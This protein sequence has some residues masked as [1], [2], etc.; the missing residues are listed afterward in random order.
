MWAYNNGI[1]KGYSSGYGGKFGVND[2]ITREQLAQVLYKYAEYKGY[3]LEYQENIRL[4]FSDQNKISNWAIPAM[5][6]AISKGIINGKGTEDPKLDP[7][8]NATRAEAA[9]MIKSFLEK[10]ADK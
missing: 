8:G 5:E 7:L 10:V 6:W 2:P 1:V 4:S 3:S 9:Q